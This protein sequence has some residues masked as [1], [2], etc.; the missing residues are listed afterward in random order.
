MVQSAEAENDNTAERDATLP[1]RSG[2]GPIAGGA[3]KADP[4]DQ[5]AEQGVLQ[6]GPEAMAL[7]EENPPERIGNNRR[8]K[9]GNQEADEP[10]LR[11]R[12]RSAMM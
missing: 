1:E 5:G 4:R 7:D 9:T 12:V 2:E 6:R 11:R 8:Q 10:L 3:D